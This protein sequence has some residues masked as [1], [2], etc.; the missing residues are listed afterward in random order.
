[1]YLE[2]DVASLLDQPRVS[3]SVL[4]AGLVRRDAAQVCAP[5][6]RLAFSADSRA[7]LLGKSDD[8]MYDAAVAGPDL[9]R[10]NPFVFS[11]ICRYREIEIRYCAVSRD[12]VLLRH[13]E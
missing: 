3:V 2:D 1:M 4:D 13:F 5:A 12:C 6:G 11:E 10:L 9:H 8:V 7:R